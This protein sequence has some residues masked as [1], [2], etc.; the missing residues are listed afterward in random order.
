VPRASLTRLAAAAVAG[1]ALGTTPSARIAARVSAHGR[2]DVSADGSG[3]PGAFNAIRL[4]G[5]GPGYAVAAADVAKGVGAS[6][7]GRRLAGDAGAHLAAVAAVVGH[8]HPPPGLDRGGKGVATSFG[9]CLATFPVF[10]PL[11]FAIAFGVSRL[12][13]RRPAAVSVASSAACWVVAGT[14]WWRRG[15]PNLWGPAPT[16]ALP[17]ANAATSLVIAFRAIAL[18]RAREPDEIALNRSAR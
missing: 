1:Y 7:V 3:N 11:D 17:L 8:C 10:A 14:V 12:R 9:Q 4:L 15:L 6:L 5:R 16:I 13:T 18:L 2:V